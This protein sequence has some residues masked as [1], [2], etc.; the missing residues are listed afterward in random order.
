MSAG[1]PLVLASASPRRRELLARAG[2]P[3]EVMPASIDEDARPGEAARR[4]ADE[5]RAL[6]ET[7]RTRR[8]P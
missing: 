2:V 1:R 3:F 4:F 8:T 6:A 5:A 7:S